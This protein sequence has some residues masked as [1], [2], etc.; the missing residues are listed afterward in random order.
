MVPR[1]K[2]LM[3]A[4]ILGRYTNLTERDNSWKPFSGSEQR[5]PVV[6]HH[7]SLIVR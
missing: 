2:N 6:V 4:A 7:V 1:Y 3:N 5:Y